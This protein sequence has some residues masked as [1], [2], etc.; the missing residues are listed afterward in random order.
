MGSLIA[1]LINQT[2]DMV[3]VAAAEQVNHPLCGQILDSSLR[4]QIK[5]LEELDLGSV[6]VVIDFTSPETCLQTSLLAQNSGCRLV[7]GTTGLSPEQLSVLRERSRHIPIVH[8]PNMA[9]GVN[10]FFHAVSILSRHFGPEYGIEVVEIHHQHKKDSPS[11]TAKRVVDLIGRSVP[12]HSLRIGEVVG[13]HQV[14]VAGHGE[15]LVLTHQA[16]TREAFALGALLAVRFVIKQ[17]KGLFD[18]W[19][20][21]D[22]AL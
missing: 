21:L 18:M 10:V 2:K 20:V 16:E 14:H 19:Q 5:K 17:Q 13:E 8:S 7:S 3:V 15:R 1:K 9:R 22:L 4:P 12:C 6:D 11:G